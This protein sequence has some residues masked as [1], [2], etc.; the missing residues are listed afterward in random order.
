MSEIRPVAPTTAP[1]YQE[2]S[3]GFSRE[4]LAA[5]RRNTRTRNSS[6]LI[7]VD[8]ATSP[9]NSRGIPVNSPPAVA[10]GNPPTEIVDVEHLITT[11]SSQIRTQLVSVIDRPITPQARARLHASIADCLEAV[12]QIVSETTVETPMVLV[13]VPPMDSTST[14]V[15]N[16][17]I[18]QEG[19]VL[20]A[21][22][23]R[24]WLP[25]DIQGMMTEEVAE[26]MGLPQFWSAIRD[27]QLPDHNVLRM[28]IEHFQHTLARDTAALWRDIWH[29]FPGI[30]RSHTYNDAEQV[31]RVTFQRFE[32]ELVTQLASQTHAVHGTWP[33]LQ[34]VS[35][36]SRSGNTACHDRVVE[37][38]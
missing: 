1:G 23:F 33:E 37:I 32:A 22:T 16:E 13:Q 18:E 38:D 7:I 14:P 8:P 3:F 10:N 26:Y 29:C 17:W 5:A 30:R 36:P 34:P 6:S 15:L 11:V 27:G 24:Q 9:V 2:S 35:V 31:R 19:Y 25:A 4:M 28:Y 20:H 21:L 12:R